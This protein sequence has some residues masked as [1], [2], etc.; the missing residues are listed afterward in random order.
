MT[1]TENEPLGQ[2]ERPS[3]LRWLG[4]L[5]GAG[6]PERNRAWVLYDT[7]G[8]TWALRHV[9]RSLLQLTPLVLAVLLAVPGPFWIRAMSAGGGLAMGL[10]YSIGYMVETTEHRLVKAGYPVGSGE[11]LRERQAS[12][13]RENGT[14]ARR[15]KM[16]ARMDRRAS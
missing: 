15:A 8:R 4:Y 12:A 10:I 11:R 7:T 13:N 3:L 2:V 14:A 6:L 9:A 16:M 5:W 1:E